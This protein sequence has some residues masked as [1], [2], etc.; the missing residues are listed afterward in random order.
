MSSVWGGGGQAP[1]NSSPCGPHAVQQGSYDSKVIQGGGGGGALLRMSNPPSPE[2]DVDHTSPTTGKGGGAYKEGQPHIPHVGG[3]GSGTRARSCSHL[4]EGGGAAVTGST[5]RRTQPPFIAR[6]RC[7]TCHTCTP[8][9]P[10][11]PVS[12]TYHNRRRV[13]GSENSYMKKEGHTIIFSKKKKE[14][15]KVVRN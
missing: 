12:L 4:G 11:N 8:P 13:D 7:T 5:T 10:T 1:P 9:P 6:R 3:G 2:G 15:A 14:F